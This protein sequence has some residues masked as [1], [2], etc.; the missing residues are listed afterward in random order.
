MHEAQ[1]DPSYILCKKSCDSF[2]TAGMWYKVIEYSIDMG[3]KVYDNKGYEHTFTLEK[4]FYTRNTI[5]FELIK[6]FNTIE[7]ED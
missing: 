1:V 5:K 6:L 7:D 4:Y 3:V 2:I